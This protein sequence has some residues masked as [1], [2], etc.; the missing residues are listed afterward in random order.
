M[1]PQ[2]S[3]EAKG[4][5]R[6]RTDY[7]FTCRISIPYYIPTRELQIM[8]SRYPRHGVNFYLHAYCLQRGLCSSGNLPV[9]QAYSPFGKVVPYQSV[10]AHGR[11]LSGDAGSRTRVSYALSRA[12]YR[13]IHI[14]PIKLGIKIRT[15]A[16][17]K[18]RFLPETFRLS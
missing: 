3:E 11:L 16:A 18:S 14:F 2:A 1:W 6:L 13:L 4:D 5:S 15:F 8:R 12:V 10:C 9:A 7:F 17:T